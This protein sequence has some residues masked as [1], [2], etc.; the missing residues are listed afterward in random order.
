M[1][2]AVVVSVSRNYRLTV[3]EGRRGK[4]RQNA[5]FYEGTSQLKY[6]A[7]KHNREPSHAVDIAP[8]TVGRDID[9]DDRERFCVLAGRMMQAFDMLQQR[10]AISPHWK[11]RWGG[12][13]DEDDDLRDNSFD[14][15]VHFELALRDGTEA[16]GEATTGLSNTTRSLGIKPVQALPPETI[17]VQVNPQTLEPISP[18]RMSEILAKEGIKESRD[19]IAAAEAV[20]VK[21]VELA[22]DGIGPTD[23]VSLIMDGDVREK[24]VEAVQGVQDLSAE[25]TDLQPEEAEVLATDAT[26]VPFRVWKALIS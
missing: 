21:I 14:D 11:L 2:Q 26:R 13:W 17:S 24:V 1:L 9:W 23:A 10:G 6:P 5:F 18:P 3:V 16:H 20:A 4:E 8:L 25:L 7:S 12:D 19:V 15:L 22:K